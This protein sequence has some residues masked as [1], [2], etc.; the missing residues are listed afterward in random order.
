MMR[1]C[2]MY[3]YQT[4]DFQSLVGNIQVCEE[5]PKTFLK[6]LRKEIH[7]M[8]DYHFQKQKKYYKGVIFYEIMYSFS[9]IPIKILIYFI[10]TSWVLNLPAVV[11]CQI[12]QGKI[13]QEYFKLDISFN[14]VI[15][16]HFQ[17][18]SYTLQEFERKLNKYLL[19]SHF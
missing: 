2:E 15:C 18:L 11:R 8:N 19:P 10:L 6:H 17:S 12:R 3:Y 13:C 9:A 16:Y 7:K 4:T 14:K 5:I 1:V